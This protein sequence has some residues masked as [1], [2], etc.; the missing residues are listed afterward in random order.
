MWG[1]LKLAKS[2]LVITR[3]M[4]LNTHQLQQMTCEDGQKF[5]KEAHVALLSTQFMTDSSSKKVVCPLVSFVVKKK[6]AQDPQEQNLN[7]KV[8]DHLH[9]EDYELIPVTPLPEKFINIIFQYARGIFKDYD[10]LKKYI[11]SE[12]ITIDDDDFY[13][14]GTDIYLC[15]PYLPFE[16]KEE[17]ILISTRK[18]HVNSESSFAK[19]L[20][21]SFIDFPKQINVHVNNK[22]MD[23]LNPFNQ[24][25]KYVINDENLV[26]KGKGDD[27]KYW[28]IAEKKIME[29]DEMAKDPQIWSVLEGILVY[30]GN[31][32]VKRDELAQPS[33]LMS[34][35]KKRTLKDRENI[36]FNQRLHGI[37]M[38]SE[39][40]EKSFLTYDGQDL[41]DQDFLREIH[42]DIAQSY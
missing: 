16:Q 2:A 30:K 38:I 23:R 33:I 32:F 3:T 22:L 42:S 11:L 37:I 6:K 8:E 35:N 4:Q 13:K 7:V 5:R 14:T 28:I 19:F 31:S 40:S 34:H 20:K 18:G 27:Y 24:I 41:A 39:N 12:S 15:N 25:I 9:Y 36:N 17:D 29:F 21:Y 26:I 10:D 1:C